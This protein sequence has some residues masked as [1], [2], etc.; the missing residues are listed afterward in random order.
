MTSPPTTLLPK[1]M[2]AWLVNRAGPPSPTTLQ[3]QTIPAPS[4]S[5]FPPTGTNILVKISHAALNPVDLHL[6]NT[7][8]TWL[9][10]RRRPPFA[11]AFDFSG[12]VAA[13]GPAVPESLGISVG[14][15]ICG[16]LNLA[17][18]VAGRGTLAEYLVCDAHLV[19]VKPEG[20]TS[21]QAAGLMGIA[22]QTTA[23]MVGFA[24]V[25]A[26]QR[27]L[28]NGASGGVGSI[29]VQALSGKGLTVYGVC[30]AGN[31]GL[32]KRLGA[33]ETVDYTRGELEVLL[34]ERFGKKQEE[35]EDQRL[36]FIFDCAGSQALFSHSEGYL[37][38]KG[39]FISIVG[40]PSQGVVP[41]VRNKLRPVFLGGVPRAYD[42]LLL[43]P[44]GKTA[45][46]IAQWVSE[47]VVREAVVDS[48]FEM[49]DVIKVSFIPTGS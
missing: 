42:L 13:L 40:G 19:A 5:P 36:D 3:L 23:L 11:P 16:A 12:E 34:K 35:E 44:S 7:L 8:P 14:T 10:F 39:R 43:L 26:G 2:R 30:S 47:G 41:Y 20:V 18:I 48:E 6:I 4:P 31:D 21:A 25:K 27:A 32:V 37:K 38:E 15:P 33:V 22:G 29:L 17:Q 1:T 45:T 49:E 28:V 24:G 9:P 46:Q